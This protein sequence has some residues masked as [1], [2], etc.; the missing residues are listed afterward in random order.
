[1]CCWLSARKQWLLTPA[2][3]A[4]GHWSAAPCSR[5][6][7]KAVQDGVDRAGCRFDAGRHLFK[8]SDGYLREFLL[9]PFMSGVVEVFVAPQGREA[10]AVNEADSLAH[11]IVAFVVGESDER[12]DELGD[13]TGSV[14]PPLRIE[15]VGGF[16]DQRHHFRDFEAAEI[17]NDRMEGNGISHDD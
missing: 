14:E 2:K 12:G 6:S 1:M 5:Q 17:R 8:E 3:K 16:F 11:R 7:W 9:D 4:N 10:G 13:G 15:V